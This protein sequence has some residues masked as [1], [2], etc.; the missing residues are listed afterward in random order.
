MK[1]Y[2]WLLAVALA[3][4]LG[5]GLL[6]RVPARARR[7]TAPVAALPEVRLV[8]AIEHGA[9]V[10]QASAVPKDH[11]VKLEIVNHDART[12]AAT[13]GGYQDR[14]PPRS[15]APG[16]IWRAEFVAD[17]PGE[18]FAWLIDGRPAGRLTVTGSHLIE[19]HR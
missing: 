17:R 19:G 11:R 16:E 14:L 15:L 8:L 5:L 7:E 3:A 1:R 10:P 4:G 9:V 18:D 12:T 13:L 6:A 2:L